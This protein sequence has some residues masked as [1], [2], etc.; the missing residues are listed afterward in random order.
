VA[1]ALAAVL[2]GHPAP[3]PPTQSQTPREARRVFEPKRLTVVVQHDWWPGGE[4]SRSVAVRL[5]GATPSEMPNASTHLGSGD[6]EQLEA[7]V[8]KCDGEECTLRVDG[9]ARAGEYSG[10]LALDPTDSDSAALELIVRARHPLVWPLLLVFLLALAV[11]ILR[12]AYKDL[13]TAVRME[14]DAGTAGGREHIGN[15]TMHAVKRIFKG[16]WRETPWLVK[17]IWPF[18]VF[19]AAFAFL[20][21]V[22]GET[23]FGT[24]PQYLSVAVAAILGKIVIDESLQ[25]GKG[26]QI[27]GA[28]TQADSGKNPPADTWIRTPSHDS[29]HLTRNAAQRRRARIRP[30][31]RG[32]VARSRR[33]FGWNVEAYELTV[34]DIPRD[35]L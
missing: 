21:P 2:A 23:N 14:P 16:L 33:G 31:L 10:T 24:W 4:W 13:S 6:G 32:R 17:V 18:A 12:Q 8:T 34:G 15:R 29:T 9:V 3:T 11:S 35:D 7:K 25:L 20:L 5:R 26:A 1:A 22:Y 27:Q 30:G 19:V 28:Q